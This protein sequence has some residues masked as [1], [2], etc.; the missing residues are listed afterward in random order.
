MLDTC[1]ISISTLKS[2]SKYHITQVAS[3]LA[4]T[5]TLGNSQCTGNLLPVLYH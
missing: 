4:I 5:K 2:N 3:A 1:D